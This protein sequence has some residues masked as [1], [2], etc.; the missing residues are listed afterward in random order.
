MK[1]YIYG[2][3]GLAAHVRGNFPHNTKHIDIRDRHLNLYNNLNVVFFFLQIKCIHY[4]CKM[5]I[6]ELL[7]DFRQ[8]YKFMNNVCQSN[9]EQIMQLIL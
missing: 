1:T 2:Y 9:M 5:P 3:A 7:V 6:C 4:K 8:K